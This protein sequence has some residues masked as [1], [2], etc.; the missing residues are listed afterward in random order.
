[1][2]KLLDFCKDVYSPGVHLYFAVNWYLAL[3][4]AL[5]LNHGRKLALDWD[6]VVAVLTIFF[7]LLYLRIIDE[8]K[9]SE[10][11]KEFNTDRPL[12]K[13]TV[14]VKDL[15]K[16]L[17]VTGA[18]APLLN[19]IFGVPVL[20]IVGIELIYSLLLIFLE[21]NSKLVRDNILLNLI[22]TYPV[23]ILLSIYVLILDLSVW[24][25]TAQMKDFLVILA[26]ACAF[27]YYEFAR[28]ISW[29]HQEQKGMRSYS[30][31]FGTLPSAFIAYS[32]GLMAA[33]MTTLMTKSW[34][35]VLLIIPLFSGLAK[36]LKSRDSEKPGAMKL[37]GTL[38]IGLF[39]GV[40]IAIGVLNLFN[41]GFH[42]LI[43][44]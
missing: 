25:E 14:T 24:N 9:D 35:P 23:N 18:I 28:K 1:M 27:L 36:L 37:S 16:F 41:Y 11:D 22:V 13:G 31:F 15:K 42:F 19:F 21:R 17:I 34:L 32:L 30:S 29:P 10:Y 2:K 38:F 26:F 7:V 8:I 4:A 3:H 39:Y 40:M 20:I 43:R 44:P 33:L 5:S 6:A 12:I